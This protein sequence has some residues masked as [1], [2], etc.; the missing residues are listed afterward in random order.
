MVQTCVVDLVFGEAGDD[1]SS[2][3]NAMGV[4]GS[5]SALPRDLLIIEA[6]STLQQPR[7]GDWN[8]STYFKV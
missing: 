6:T 1:A 8:L 3:Q 7:A 2:N 4:L 5:S